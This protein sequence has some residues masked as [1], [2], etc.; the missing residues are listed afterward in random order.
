MTLSY[1]KLIVWSLAMW[2]SFTPIIINNYTGDQ[3]ATSRTNLTTIASLLFGVFLCSIVFGVEKLLVQLIALQFH[4]DS[5]EDRLKEQKFQ[6]RCLTTLYINSRDIPGRTDTLTDAQSTK[7]KGSQIPK[8]ALRKALRGLREVAQT[9]TTALGNVASEM[10]GHSPRSTRAKPS[11]EGCSTLSVSPEPTTSPLPTLPGSS[12][13]SRPLK[14][15]SRCLTRT[16]TEMR[17]G[18]RLRAPWSRST[19]TG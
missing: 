13:T 15:R 7:T 16:G 1:A 9:T 10:A 18:T 14:R 19:G 4:Q 3:S 12:P 8:I 6:I 17:P 11:R 5:Y 2:V